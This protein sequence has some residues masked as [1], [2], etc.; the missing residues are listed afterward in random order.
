MPKPTRRGEDLNKTRC[1][2]LFGWTRH[3]FDQH[4]ISG[5]PVVSAASSKH[6]EWIVN[7]AAVVEWIAGRGAEPDAADLSYER[8]RA[9]LAK[10]QADAVAIKNATARTE[11]LPAE[12]VVAGWQAAIGRCRAL[13][14]GIPPASA[15]HL[16]LIARQHEDATAAERAMREHLTRQIDAALTELANTSLD[17]DDDDPKPADQDSAE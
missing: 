10:E 13:L 1:C 14:L 12:E 3:Q 17:E 7:T 11:L 4:V 8:E 2:A 15:P 6:V 9:R 16:V 5:M